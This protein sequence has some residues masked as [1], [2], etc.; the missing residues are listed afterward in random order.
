LR[1]EGRRHLLV[2]T[3]SPSDT[4]PEPLDGYQATRAFYR[5]IGFVY[6]RD[7]PGYWSWD[8]PVLLV[9]TL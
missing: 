9:R 4:S 2:L 6:L 5:S 1:R 7:F 8:L 3:V